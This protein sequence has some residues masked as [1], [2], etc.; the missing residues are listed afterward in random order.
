M[1]WILIP[2]GVVIG[3]CVIVVVTGMLLPVKHV[4]SRTASLKMT[5]EAV[6]QAITSIAELPS[7][8]KNLQKVELLPDR[9]GHRVWKETD[10]RGTVITFEIM[11]SEAPRRLV[12]RIADTDLA[13]GG[14]WTYE[15]T[16]SGEGSSLT[17][18]ENGEVYN[19]IFRFVS[20][21]I[22]GHTASIDDYLEGLKKVTSH[23]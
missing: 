14:S 19:P 23:E 13:F 7:W 21:F 2:L 15:I 18:T 3:V 1:K 8:R 20:R 10:A 11:E 17:I 4:A 12:T 22:M 6:W 5:P 9:N 16:T